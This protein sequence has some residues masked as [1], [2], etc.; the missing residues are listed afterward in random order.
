LSY[1][2]YEMK[3]EIIYTEDCALIVSD[4]GIKPGDF[5]VPS[6][7]N[8]SSDISRTSEEDLAIVNDK[9]NGYKKIIGHRPFT[10]AAILEGVPLLPKFKQEDDVKK[11]AEQ[12][13]YLDF[14]SPLFEELG[15][16]KKVQKSILIGMLQ[17]TFSR[18]Y[19]KA[20]ETYKHTEEDMIACWKYSSMDK[21]QIIGDQI[22][23]HYLSFIQSLQQPKRPKYFQIEMLC[24]VNP[25]FNEYP[26]TTT[27]SQGQTELVGEYIYE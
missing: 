10:S 18:G 19:N 13:F 23:D 16:T 5:N 14:D 20:K 27:N 7:C 3:Y 6:D 25:E 15:I 9:F 17:G 11:I 4:E 12:E 1:I 24:Y 22:G 2:Q 26:K 8:K 21:H